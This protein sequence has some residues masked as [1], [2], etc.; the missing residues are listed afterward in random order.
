M[1]STP[2]TAKPSVSGN[3]MTASPQHFIARREIASSV[4]NSAIRFFAATSLAP[5][6]GQARHPVP[7]IAILPLPGVDRPLVDLEIVHD[8]GDAAPGPE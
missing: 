6:T 7:V 3:K 8:V 5:N 4:S 2:A 1:H